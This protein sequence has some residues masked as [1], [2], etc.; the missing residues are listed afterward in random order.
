MMERGRGGRVRGGK[1]Y[2]KKG[3]KESGGTCTLS[4]GRERRNERKGERE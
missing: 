1:G 4:R 2:D 3:R